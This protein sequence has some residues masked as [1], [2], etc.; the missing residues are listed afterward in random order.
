MGYTIA[1][2]IGVLTGL[3]VPAAMWMRERVRRQQFQHTYPDRGPRM[4]TPQPIRVMVSE[5]NPV[6]NRISLR[7][8][9]SRNRVRGRRK[10]F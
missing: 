4:P 8:I 1:W 6:M 2:L 10:T 5:G 9:P 3:L 7:S